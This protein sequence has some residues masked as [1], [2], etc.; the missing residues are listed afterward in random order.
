MLSMSTLILGISPMLTAIEFIKPKIPERNISEIVEDFSDSFGTSHLY[1]KSK[2]IEKIVFDR[3]K[4]YPK[5]D[6]YAA[7]AL[8]AL[9]FTKEFFP[10]FFASSR[11]VGWVA[12]ILEQYEDATLLRPIQKYVGELERRFVPIGLR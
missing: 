12:H 6:F 10:L 11:I 8:D 2:K 1:D 5:V 7:V 4:I 3:K 9:G